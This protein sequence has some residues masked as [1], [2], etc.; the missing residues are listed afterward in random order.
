[1]TL[2]AGNILL[3]SMNLMA[4]GGGYL[5]PARATALMTFLTGFVRDDSML[6]HSL[7]SAKGNTDHLLGTSEETLLMATMAPNDSM[8]TG[9]PTVPGL[10]HKVARAA[11]VGVILNIF[12]DTQR[13]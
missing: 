8:S 1:M 11:E 5:K 13:I 7:I 10:F 9:C 6:F 12:I 2:D 4:S 3:F